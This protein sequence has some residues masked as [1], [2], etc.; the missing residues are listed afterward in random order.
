[1]VNKMSTSKADQIKQSLFAGRRPYQKYYE[2]GMRASKIG[3]SL[4]DNP[5]FYD[6]DRHAAWENGYT[7][8]NYE[9]Y[10]LG[11]ACLADSQ[12]DD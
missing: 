1:M 3:L 8:I 2:Q 11:L 5:Y 6:D 12:R 7:G 10:R 4:V 9:I